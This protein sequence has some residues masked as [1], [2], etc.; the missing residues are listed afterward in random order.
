MRKSAV[1]T[2]LHSIVLSVVLSLR[3]H[4][5]DLAQLERFCLT[6]LHTVK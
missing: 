5:A 1:V 6:G 3:V 2:A 4:F